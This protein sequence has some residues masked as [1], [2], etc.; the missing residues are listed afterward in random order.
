MALPDRADV[1]DARTM[2]T[3]TVIVPVGMQ[4]EAT[5]IMPVADAV[6]GALDGAPIRV[7]HVVADLE[8]T[9]I[10]VDRTWLEGVAA[11][12]DATL[13][14][15][16]HDS[17]ST[18]LSELL[19]DLPDAVV[20]MTVDATGGRI[21]SLLGSVAEDLLR[22]GHHRCVLV[23]PHVVP[24]RSLADGPVVVC[25]DG[26]PLS[27]SILPDAAAWTSATSGTAWVVS[28]VEA[29]STHS[30]DVSESAYV[31]AIADGLDTGTVQW[32]ALHGTD[33][34]QAI[35]AFAEQVDAASVVLATHGRTGLARLALG[36]TAIRVVHDAPCPVLVRRPKTLS[37]VVEPPAGSVSGRSGDR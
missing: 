21:D 2:D 11:R 37:T 5:R 1:P 20:C 13:Q 31:R 34:A 32:E 10:T 18:A 4:R 26:S 27:E 30:P 35:V 36:S 3:T 8:G 19:V 14:L 12:H 17:V 9:T 33:P 15:L 22:A 28:V 24:A 6:S 29:P 16:E 23:G 25:V 7:V